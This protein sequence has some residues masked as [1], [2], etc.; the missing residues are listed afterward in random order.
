MG[1]FCAAGSKWAPRLLFPL[2]VYVWLKARRYVTTFEGFGRPWDRLA[3]RI[4][5]EEVEP[6]L[7]GAGYVVLGIKPA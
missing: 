7:A 2:N 1:A 5:V 4:H 3:E 6:V